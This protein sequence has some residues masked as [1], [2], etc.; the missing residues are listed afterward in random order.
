VESA[1]SRLVVG[2][3]LCSG[4]VH[5]HSREADDSGNVLGGGIALNDEDQ[6]A[7]DD[8]EE[9]QMDDKCRK[10]YRNRINEIINFL[11]EHYPEYAENGVVVLSAEDK[12]DKKQFHWRNDRDLVYTGLN[13]KMIKAFLARKKAKETVNGEITKY[14]SCSHMRKYDD[15][16]KWGA[17]VKGK[18]LPRAYFQEISE[19]F[20]PAYKKEFASKKKEGKTDERD[21]DPICCTLFQMICRWAIEEGNIFVWV[22]SLAM[23]NLMSRSISVDSL[24]F[25]NFKR[26]TSDSFKVKFDETKSDKTGEFTQE[27]NCYANP[28][29]PVVCFMTAL[30]V[31]I[32]LQSE[33]LSKT[34]LLFI[35]P[36]ASLKSA[37]QRYCRQLAE[38]CNRH[39]E[40]AKE[41]LR[42]SR[43]NAHG[44][45]K[46]SGTHASSATT[47][48][49]SFVSVAARGEWSMGK[50]L[51]V[52]F[53]FAMGGDYYL[54]RILALLDPNDVSFATLPPHWKDP[55]HEKVVEGMAIA[56]G[57]VLTAWSETAFDP[58]GV[59]SLVFASLVYHSEWLIDI[60]TKYEN[61]PFNKLAILDNIELLDELRR[62]HL[63]FEA[64]DHVGIA[65]GI[66]PHISH[67]KDIKKVLDISTETKASVDDFRACL[68][69]CIKNAIDEK[70]EMEDGVNMSILQKM[71]SEL[72][73][74]ITS[75]IDSVAEVA[76][77]HSNSEDSEDGGQGL[78]RAQA[79]R[80]P[81]PHQ[82]HYADMNGELKYWCVPESFRLPRETTRKAGWGFWFHGTVCKEEGVAWKIKPFREL[83]EGDLKLK[84]TKQDLK[85]WRS[86]YRLME[87]A[88]T[89][90][91]DFS[92]LDSSFVNSSYEEATEMLKTNYSFLF[93]NNAEAKTASWSLGTWSRNTKRSEVEKRGSASD[94]ARLP[95]ANRLN[96]PHNRKRS[97]TVA[98]RR[99]V[100][101]VAKRGA[102]K[103]RRRSVEDSGDDALDV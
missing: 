63:T 89:I 16:I 11:T 17:K 41:H 65:T 84:K 55:Q 66:P 82:F 42:M 67:A 100:N 46:G 10:D 73:G 2:S 83:S 6:D 49:P 30:A 94:K 35:I 43:L 4:R 64:N 18:T 99:G 72:E 40:Y 91:A 77:P 87:T 68:N 60:K 88:I 27:K 12:A 23:W 57:D 24:G 47:L 8:T 90:P 96:V 86:V 21:A 58:S 3:M 56:F 103:R 70:V 29:N 7:I 92:E 22:Y 36:G 48:P 9:K 1:L 71:L 34:E 81:G 85:T 53:K 38:I 102:P 19:K 101:K 54:G 14:I 80:V 31:W 28:F 45:R 74:R 25:R 62:D 20:I 52:Y 39:W 75:K 98:D 97:F 79:P 51:D 76:N 44:I 33:L 59:L 78:C 95:Q 37:S 5:A 32:S 93:A 13:W 50:I 69:D 15:A 61:H 26:G